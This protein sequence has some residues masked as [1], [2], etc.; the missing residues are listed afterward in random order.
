MGSLTSTAP[1]PLMLCTKPGC[2]AALVRHSLGC[3]LSTYRCLSCIQRGNKPAQARRPSALERF[4]R[5]FVSWRE[6]D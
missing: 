1:G 5:E 6:T 3:G 4:A 2:G